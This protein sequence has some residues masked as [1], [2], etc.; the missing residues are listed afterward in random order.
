MLSLVL[1]VGM[2]STGTI[3]SAEVVLEG[4]RYDIAIISSLVVLQKVYGG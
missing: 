3:C 4:D 1:R 2:P